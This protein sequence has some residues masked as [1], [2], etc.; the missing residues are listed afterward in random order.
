MSVI[1]IL[2]VTRYAT[3]VNRQHI[4]IVMN[5]AERSHQDITTLYNITHSLYSSLSYQQITLHVCSVLANL[6][7]SLYYM[8]EVTIHTMDYVGAA[9]TGILSPH[10]LPVENLRKMLLHIEETLPLTMHLPLSSEDALHSYRYLHTHILI[11]DE[12]FLLLINVPI[13]DCTWQIEVY[14]VFNLAIPHGNFS[15]CYNIN[16]RYLGV[17]HDETKAV[18]ISE[19]QFN[20]CQKANR[21]ICSINTPLLPRANP[22]TCIAALYAKDTVGIKKRCSR[23]IRKANSVSIPTPIAPNIW[24]WTSALTAVSTGIM[25]IYPEEAP[26]FIK[27][28]TPILVLQ[29]P[30]A[31]SATSQYFHLPPCYETHELTINISLNTGNLNVMNISLPE[32]RI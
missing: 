30:P 18:E 13:Q 14:E 11:A 21:Q 27:T 17:T 20:T 19:E 10:L 23:Q 31:C 7:D 32:F 22:P 2:N 5:T 8:R 6:R 28:L 9:T 16:N 24:I 4:N 29:L 15:A 26:R 12:Q 1:S 25:L 3:Q